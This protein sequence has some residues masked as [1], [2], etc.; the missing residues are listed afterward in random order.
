[1]VKSFYNS[2]VL[3]DVIQQFQPLSAD[4]ETMRKFAKWRATHIHS[5]LK[6]GETPV[7]PNTMIHS[8]KEDEEMNGFT[9][10]VKDEEEATANDP[11]PSLPDIPSVPDE[12]PSP[13]NSTPIPAV[14]VQP[15]IPPQLVAVNTNPSTVGPEHIEKAQKYCKWA[16]SALNYDD[17]KTAVDNLQKALH[18]LT[19]GTEM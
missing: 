5:C 8:S 13:I 12:D 15:Y 10:T 3:C 14:P 2:A 11:S 4:F 19:T 1:M 9:E 16:S 7:P 17:V 6:V 18:L